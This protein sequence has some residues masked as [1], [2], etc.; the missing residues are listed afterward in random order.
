MA[1]LLLQTG[2]PGGP[3]VKPAPALADISGAL[4]G[5]IG[6]VSALWQRER[7]GEGQRVETNLLNGALALLSMHY[8]IYFLNGEV[9]PPVGA[10]HLQ[11]IP[12]GAY[13]TRDGW[14][15]IGASWPRITKSL[16]IEWVQEDPRFKG[17]EAR[18]KNRAELEKIITEALSVMDTA[19]WVEILR[20]DDIAC[21]PVYNLDTAPADPQIQ[22]NDMILE[23][24]HS[25]GGAVRL[26][27]NP[28]K[29]ASI[30]QDEYTAP[31]TLG[32]HSRDVLTGLLGYS[33]DK[34][35]KLLNE[36]Q[37]RFEEK[38]QHNPRKGGF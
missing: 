38:Q 11:A 32:Q 24:A 1:G 28:I 35:E 19:T 16:N 31:P 7:T 6:T 37:R 21:G 18:L 36:Q 33:E 27:G 5:V 29:S 23:L 12:F 17:L 2:H 3:P 10:G 22:H 30:N 20:A 25:L 26:I 9:P 8:A 15:S 14:I 13:R 34:A 4:F